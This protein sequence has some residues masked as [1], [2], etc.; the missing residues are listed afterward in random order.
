[1]SVLEMLP[2]TPE[3]LLARIDAKSSLKLRRVLRGLCRELDAMFAGLWTTTS[4]HGD[5]LIEYAG[6]ISY[7]PAIYPYVSTSQPTFDRVRAADTC[8]HDAVLHRPR[9]GR[10]Q[11]TLGLIV[12]SF[13]DMSANVIYD[14]VEHFAD[15]IEGVLADVVG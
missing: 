10:G 2:G 9:L 3:R 14:I 4:A 11:P 15:E 8:E 5:V 12:V 13:G 6:E 7:A 1:M